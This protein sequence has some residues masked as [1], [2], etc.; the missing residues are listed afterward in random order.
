[1]NQYNEKFA[2]NP[3]SSE[4]QNIIASAKFAIVG[5]GGIGGFVLENLVR[6]GAAKFLV[7]DHD[8]FELS[9]FNR[10][11]LATDNSLGKSKMKEAM[12]RARS[13]NKNIEIEGREKFASDSDLAGV[14]LIIDAT[15]NIKTKI[16]ICS[17]A[18]KH[19]IPDVFSSAGYGRG[20]VTVFIDYDIEKAFHL[21]DDLG[22][23]KR[24]VS[25]L[26]S[27]AAISGSLAA[28][29]AINVVLGKPFAKAPNAIFF[30]LF[31][32][33]VFWRAKLG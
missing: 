29:Q 22:R 18:K 9:N 5:M 26:S 16:A 4:E 21:S 14:E 17:S 8:K 13:I 31:Q 2:R 19:N 11:L 32:E 24:P 15:D 25:V 3:F 6:S 27:A 10:Q 23:Y 20:I 12:E 28:S 1:M 33:D 7:F 30:D